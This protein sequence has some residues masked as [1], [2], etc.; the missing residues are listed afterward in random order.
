MNLPQFGSSILELPWTSGD[1]NFDRKLAQK[2]QN[3]GSPVYFF[4]I[5]LALYFF[6]D[7]VFFRVHSK[8]PFSDVIFLDRNFM[9]NL[10]KAV[11]KRIKIGSKKAKFWIAC[12]FFDG[13]KMSTFWSPLG[14]QMMSFW[15]QTDLIQ[16][17]RESAFK[18]IQKN[19][20]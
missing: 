7:A 15:H 8:S 1:P 12:I 19:T 13:S 9:K 11:K 2:K 18:K 10:N 3:F 6:F 5:F 20:T 16:G 17:S 4:I 14:W